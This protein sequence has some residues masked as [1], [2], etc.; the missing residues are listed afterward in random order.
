LLPEGV[1]IKLPL[2][3]LG[4]IKELLALT[5]LGLFSAF[6]GYLLLKEEAKSYAIQ[7]A[8]PIIR[9]YFNFSHV[10]HHPLNLLFIFLVPTLWLMAL[11]AKRP[12]PRI[13]F[14]FFGALF[15]FRLVFGFVF[16]NVLVFLPAA[17]PPLL[18]G[19]IIAYLPFFVMTWGWLM[20]RIDCRGQGSPQ[21]VIAIPEAEGAINS[22]EYYHASANS[23][24]NQGKSGFKG[25]TKLGRF[26]VMIH[27]LM[28]LDVLGI[29]LVRAYG[30]VQKML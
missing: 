14:D 17:S 27:S 28:V 11:F 26:L 29:A 20:W 18:L 22:F 21:Q 1:V 12:I 5:L 6:S 16:V 24:I 2:N 15:V 3:K 4:Q 9:A 19:Q 7:N 13:I 8:N 10:T 30:L 23:V 25:V